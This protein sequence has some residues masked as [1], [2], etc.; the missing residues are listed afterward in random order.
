MTFAN[1]PK[2][3]ERLGDFEIGREIGRGGMGVVFE[4][5]QVSLN[6]KVAVKVLIGLGLSAKAVER[7]RREAEAAARL[8]H[9]NIVPVYASGEDNG[10]HYYAME[11]IDGPSLAEVIQHL[12]RQRGLAVGPGGAADKSAEMAPTGPFVPALPGSGTT[13]SSAS[14]PSGGDHFDWIACA[15]AEVADGLEH[16]HGQGVIHRDIKPSNLLLSPDGRLSVND[17]G[18]ARLLEQPGMTLSGEFVGT[19]AYM[20]PEQITA[21]RAP[22]DRRTDIYSLGATLYELLTLQR[23]YSG[24]RREQVIAQIIHKEPTPPRALTKQVPVDLETICQK[25]MEKDPDQRYQTAEALADDLRRYVNR[26][27]IRARRAGPITRLRKWV[28][29]HPGLTA[30]LAGML[31]LALVAGV[32][33]YL[34]VASERRRLEEQGQLAEQLRK[35]R[36]QAALER[37]LLAA[38]GGDFDEAD[39]AAGAAE[40]E[41]ASTGQVEFL[42]GEIAYYRGPVSEA[43]KHLERAIQILPMDESAAARALLAMSYGNVS[44]ENDFERLFRE[45]EP[46]VPVTLEDYLF[47]GLT[48]SMWKPNEGLRLMDEAVRRRPSSPIARLFRAD[49]RALMATDRYDPTVA[50]QAIDD[51]MTAR[52]LL[53][54]NS[55][56]ALTASVNVH[57]IAAASYEVAGLPDKRRAALAQAALDA[58]GLKAFPDQSDASFARMSYLWYC[59]PRSA[60]LD[61]AHRLAG[62]TKNPLIHAFRALTLYRSGTAENLEEA[63][64][65]LQTCRGSDYPDL[66]HCWCWPS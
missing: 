17:F 1:G 25:A 32:F 53:P 4:A 27:A 14:T 30:G 44:R 59:G 65:A 5:R 43:I 58:E 10:I 19:P 48:V 26:F 35:E 11:L 7:F 46:I 42:Y 56:Q 60:A 55:L 29:R 37:A 45:L 8:H 64:A 15:I 18:L 57:K 21:G 13:G 51:V 49:A 31:I 66:I 52:K 2:P 63:R 20:S 38:M 39:R 41:G 28:R 9:T 6:R 50:D 62:R 24:A 47:K 23:P 54:E 33:G 22:L 61:E 40:R 16:A 36:R 34:A 12:R 3:G